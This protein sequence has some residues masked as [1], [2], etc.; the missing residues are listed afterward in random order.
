MEDFVERALK[1]IKENNI[2]WVDLQFTDLPGRFHHITVSA[3]DFNE[4]AFKNGFGKLDGSSIRGFTE[5]YESDL[6]LVPVPET[7]TIVPWNQGLARAI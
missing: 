2:K 4:D 1:I 6:V 7:F 5:I 3:K